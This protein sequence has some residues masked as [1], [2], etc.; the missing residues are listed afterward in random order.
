[1]TEID[2]EPFTCE[3]FPSLEFFLTDSGGREFVSLFARDLRG[4]HGTR[5]LLNLYR[6]NRYHLFELP[7]DFHPSLYGKIT[8]LIAEED[9][10]N[11]HP[12]PPPLPP[13]PANTILG[14][15]VT[16]TQATQPESV[17]HNS[18]LPTILTSLKI[19]L[20]E[21]QPLLSND[22]EVP[23]SLIANEPDLEPGTVNRLRNLYYRIIRLLE[24]IEEMENYLMLHPDRLAHLESLRVAPVVASPP[25]ENEA[26]DDEI[27]F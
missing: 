26:P 25:E 22:M 23:I 11:P 9:E 10:S 21:L 18:P 12:E 27:D 19:K 2:Q 24:H 14:W 5:K 1:M 15:G 3:A 6:T 20:Q 16:S 17:T 7:S 4:R 8:P 13:F